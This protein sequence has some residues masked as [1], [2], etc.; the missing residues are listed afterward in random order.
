M[1]SGITFQFLKVNFEISKKKLL[2]H[3]IQKL[4]TTPAASSIERLHFN[5]APICAFNNIPKPSS[6]YSIC[7]KEKI[8]IP[9]V[10]GCVPYELSL[11]VELKLH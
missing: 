6:A 4:F 8:S 1:L 10:K 5:Y 9:N 2:P 11:K 7:T 3:C